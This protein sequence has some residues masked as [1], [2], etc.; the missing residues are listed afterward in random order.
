MTMVCCFSLTV[1][2]ATRAKSS[3][4]WTRSRQITP[5]ATLADGSTFLTVCPWACALPPSRTFRDALEVL[6][7][8]VTE[9]TGR[10]YLLRVK[11]F[12]SD[13]QRVG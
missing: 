8:G 4:G 11:S 13:A 3:R 10:Q 7:A 2:R 1:V 5:G 9:T 6:R 12:L